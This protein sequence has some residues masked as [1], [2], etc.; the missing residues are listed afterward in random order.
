MILHNTSVVEGMAKST[1]D[2]DTSHW[3][4]F[5]HPL[6]NGHWNF[7]HHLIDQG[8]VSSSPIP[9]ERPLV[10]P[11]PS[12]MRDLVWDVNGWPLL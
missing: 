8:Q 5:F 1:Q 11:G 12:H 7:F 6:G 3:F 2:E 10:L 4:D 9:C